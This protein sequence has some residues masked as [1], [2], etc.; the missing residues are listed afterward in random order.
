MWLQELVEGILE[1]KKSNKQ[2]NFQIT[3]TEY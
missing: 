2:K 1:E 3:E